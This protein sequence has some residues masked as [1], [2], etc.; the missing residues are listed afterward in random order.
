MIRCVR[1]KHP[2]AQIDFLVKHQFQDLLATN[3]HLNNV[4]VFEKAGQ[5]KPLRELRSRIRSEGYDWIIDI[6]RNLRS[7]YLSRGSGANLVTR[8]S[9]KIFYRSMLVYLGINLYPEVEP[10]M[11]R[12]FRA[13]NGRGIQY[14]GMQTEIPVPDGYGSALAD[15]FPG[16]A[17]DRWTLTICPGASF[18]NKRWLPDRFLEVAKF[19]S[20]T[21]GAQIL[22]L[23]GAG[24]SDLCAGLASEISGSINLAGE[25]SL[26]ESAAILK[27]S[28]LV[29]TNDSGMM[30][31]AQSQ[32][33]PLVAIFGPTTRE[34]GYFP[35]PEQSAVVEADVACRPCTHNG[36][37][38][39]PKRHFRCMREISAEM[40]LEAA[41]QFDDPLSR[42]N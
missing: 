20:G 37:D 2:K 27:G 31:L 11:L 5:G 7:L 33:V 10:V 4:I 28:N 35:M 30:H 34:L 8:H 22:F 17:G 38:H 41:G 40:I 1:E 36:L 26:L 21:R 6:H 42:T 18:A 14:D 24:D 29:V 9:K 39:C 19:Y 12:Y 32:K 23:G 3:P 15:R 13:V 16:L 25:L